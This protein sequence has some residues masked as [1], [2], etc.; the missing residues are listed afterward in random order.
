MKI[1]TTETILIIISLILLG[2]IVNYVYN[3]VVVSENSISGDKI[4]ISSFLEKKSVECFDRYYGSSENIDCYI[5]DVY[6]N[7]PINNIESDK[8]NITMTKPI[9]KGHSKV[10]VQYDAE[11]EKINLVVM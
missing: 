1:I 8:I 7:K 5:I 2:A 11:K 4:K 6:T 9:P 3:W 10:K